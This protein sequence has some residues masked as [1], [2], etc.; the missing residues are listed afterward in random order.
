MQEALSMLNQYLMVSKSNYV[1]SIC[2]SVV[3]SFGT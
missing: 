2:V 3:I 1:D